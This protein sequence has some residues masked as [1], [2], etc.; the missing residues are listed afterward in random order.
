ME[1]AL[2]QYFPDDFTWSSPQ[3]GIFLWTGRPGKTD[4]DSFLRKALA[5]GVGFAP[6][7]LFDPA[8][9]EDWKIRLNF[10]AYTEAELDKGLRILGSLYKEEPKNRLPATH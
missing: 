10:A 7:F 8:G 3:G 1:S 6:G 9:G 2:R 4:H 5:R